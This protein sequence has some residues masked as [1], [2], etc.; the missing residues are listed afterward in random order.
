MQQRA[1][2]VKNKESGRPIRELPA[3]AGTRVLNTGKK[4]GHDNRARAVPVEQGPGPPRPSDLP[5]V[6]SQKLLCPVK[7]FF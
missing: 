7:T 1:Q 5:S 4:L 3:S 2:A 6:P